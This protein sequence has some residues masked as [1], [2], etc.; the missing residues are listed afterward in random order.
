VSIDWIDWLKLSLPCM[1]FRMSWY[2]IRIECFSEK[3]SWFT[4][5]IRTNPNQFNLIQFSLIQ[6]ISI[7]CIWFDFQFEMVLCTYLRY[8]RVLELE[9]AV[10]LSFLCYL[11]WF[12]AHEA[13]DVGLWS[14]GCCMLA[15]LSEQHSKGTT[16]ITGIGITDTDATGTG[17]RTGTTSSFPV[18][19][20]EVA[21]QVWKPL[22][23]LPQ[24]F[25]IS[26]NGGQRRICILD[27]SPTSALILI[28]NNW[29]KLQ[30]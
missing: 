16:S 4:N 21:Y 22:V 1:A 26:D 30:S 11:L 6:F 2:M 18:R 17:A 29:T 14:T 27:I 5:H 20:A 7:K 12:G 24:W 23:A 13:A 8:V 10:R 3:L 9:S 15:L 28:Q 25:T 19:S